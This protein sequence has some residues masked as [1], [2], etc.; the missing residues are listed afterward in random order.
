MDILKVVAEYAG[1]HTPQE[2]RTLRQLSHCLSAFREDV[3]FVEFE[4]DDEEE[5][6]SDDKEEDDSDNEEDY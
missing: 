2:L 3:P 6:N 4:S 5:D 1:D